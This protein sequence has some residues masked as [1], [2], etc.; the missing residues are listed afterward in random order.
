MKSLYG[1]LR[2]EGYEIDVAEHPADALRMSL[3][4]EYSAVVMDSGNVGFSAYDAA[5]AIRSV[6]GGVSVIIAGEEGP[7]PDSIAV[8]KPVD[9]EEVRW[10]L[11]RLFGRADFQERRVQ[12]L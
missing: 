2:Q 4:K 6:S 12:G 7:T 1:V 9:P 3:A 5:A 11:R 10:V 8:G